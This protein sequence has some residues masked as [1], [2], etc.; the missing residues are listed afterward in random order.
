MV[1]AMTMMVSKPLTLPFEDAGHD[2]FTPEYQA[3]AGKVG[4]STS[5]LR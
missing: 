3:G 1:V 2:G 5:A 4:Q